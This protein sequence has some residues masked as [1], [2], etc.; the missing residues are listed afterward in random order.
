[1]YTTFFKDSELSMEE[2]E[3]IQR[4][5]TTDNSEVGSVYLQK[6][7]ILVDLKLAKAIEKSA[8]ANNKS[9]KAMIILTLILAAC[10][11]IQ[12]VLYV[13]HK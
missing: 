11:I 3:F 8:D 10:A 2:K 6:E 7:K 5:A 4:I 1:M 9:S 12:V 13:I